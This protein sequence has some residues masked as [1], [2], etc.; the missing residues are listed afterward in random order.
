[1]STGGLA[2]SEVRTTPRGKVYFAA[3]GSAAPTD[4]TSALTSDWHEAGYLDN[5]SV[6]LS[7]DVSTSPI[8]KWQSTMPVKYTLDEVSMEVKFVMNQVNKQN[9]ELWLFGAQWANEAAGNAHVT[10]PA[11]PSIQDLERALIVEFDDDRDDVTRWYF[12]RG[13]VIERDEITLNK[14]DIKLGLTYHVMADGEDM[15]QIFSTN[16]DLYS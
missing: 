14:G 4:S 7:P 5:D 15:F 13:I 8:M 16:D 9:T 3:V 11:S 1:M 12:S 6:S 10:V 2:A